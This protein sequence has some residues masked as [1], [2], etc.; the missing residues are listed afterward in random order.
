MD[1]KQETAQTTLLAAKSPV[2]ME[3]MC[4]QDDD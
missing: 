1:S 3:A 2:L 4:F